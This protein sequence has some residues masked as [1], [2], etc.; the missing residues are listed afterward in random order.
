MNT[1]L[2]LSGELAAAVER[3]GRAMFAVHG[4]PRVPSTGVHWRPGFV[5][6]ANHTLHADEELRLT[7]PDGGSVAGALVGR[8]PARDLAVVRVRAQLAECK[9]KLDRHRAALEAGAD[10]TIVTKW[11]A[12]V[13]ADRRRALAVLNQPAARP[14]QRMTQEQI[15]ELVAK[16]GD[17]MAVLHDADPD[18]RAE[19]Y[20]QLGLRLTYHPEEQKIRVQAQPDADPNGKIVCVRGGT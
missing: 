8:D 14:T 4:R 11:I 7:R 16:L 3:T 1:L 20:R 10:P 6:T 13:E 17:I 19:V 9:T 2:A 18:D 15:A 5:V 12:E